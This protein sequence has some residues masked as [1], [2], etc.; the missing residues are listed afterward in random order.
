MTSV[1]DFEVDSPPSDD[2]LGRGRFH[3]SD[4]YSVF[5]WGEMP[6]RIPHKGASLCTMG[7]HHF[8]RLESEGIPTHYR[9]VL[10][11]GAP[12]PLGECDHPPSRMSIALTR[13]PELPFRN[14]S[15]DYASYH[16]EGGGNY[17]IPLEIVFRNRVPTGSSLRRRTKPSD[18]GLDRDEWPEEPL[19]LERPIVEY[20]TKYE[21]KDRYLSREEAERIAGRADLEDLEATARQVN[22]IINDRAER[23]GFTHEDGKIEC[24][25]HEGTI[26]VADVVGT[27]DENRF[28]YGPQP[29][30]KEVIRQ[31]YRTYHPEWIRACEE[32][33][34]QARREGKVD[35][36]PLCE[37]APRPL[38]DNVVSTIRD[39]YAAGTNAYTE[40]TWFEAP[41]MDRVLSDLERLT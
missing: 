29:I 11:D 34:Q 28:S 30:S 12:G 2:E 24:L 10:D 26:Y 4:R 23:G 37:V 5:D 36:R 8:E 7:A 39:M 16:R 22:A 15:Y 32:A 41:S 31:F 13:V 33:R 25:Y 6:D 1:K 21:E 14:G 27:F 9:G 20:S 18:H 35:W 38:P 40:R 3:F 19:E 17:L